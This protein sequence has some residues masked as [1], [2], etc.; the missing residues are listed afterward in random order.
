MMRTTSQPVLSL[1]GQVE[2]VLGPRVRVAFV[3][4]PWLSNT[5]R[6]EPEGGLEKAAWNPRSVPRPITRGSG[7]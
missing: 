3:F 2:Q 6:A 5:S 1:E 4:P 7:S